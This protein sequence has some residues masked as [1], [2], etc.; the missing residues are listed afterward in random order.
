MKESTAF[1]NI[2]LSD[3]RQIFCCDEAL[4]QST[5]FVTNFCKSFLH[6][7]D[8]DKKELKCKKMKIDHEL[9]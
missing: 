4:E 6:I 2:L 1:E 9:I 7:A 8:L 5:M 3:F